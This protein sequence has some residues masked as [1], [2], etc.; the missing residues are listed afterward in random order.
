MPT[1]AAFWKGMD[2]E[3]REEL[4]LLTPGQ[5]RR[6]KKCRVQL[7]SALAAFLGRKQLLKRKCQARAVLAALIDFLG[8]S[9]ADLVLVTLEDLWLETE[10]QNTPGTSTERVNWR[11]KLRKPLEQFRKDPAVQRLLRKLKAGRSKP[12]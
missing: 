8:R 1:W 3:D 4:G 5:S 7:R 6:E 11:R 9:D 2:I 12:I 10:P